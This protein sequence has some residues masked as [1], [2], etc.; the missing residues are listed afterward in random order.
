[1][2]AA[3][4]NASTDNIKR[5]I[6]SRF[7]QSRQ[8]Q[9]FNN[10]RKFSKSYVFDKISCQSQLPQNFVTRMHHIFPEKLFVH[11]VIFSK[12]LVLDKT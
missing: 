2:K 5:K 10:L 8:N 3:V 11:F 6:Q 7:Y 12:V 9:I 4:S 1:M